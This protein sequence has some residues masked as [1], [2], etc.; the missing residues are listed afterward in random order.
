MTATLWGLYAGYLLWLLAGCVDFHCHR[1]TDLAQ[2]SGLRESVLHLLQTGLM[3][4]MLVAW[5]LLEPSLALAMLMG[6]LVLAHAM[7]GYADTRVAWP[8]RAITPLEQHVHSVL[9]TAPWIVLGVVLYRDGGLAM[10]Q[11]W[12][13]AWRSPLPPASA[14]AAVLAPALLLCVLPLLQELRAAWRARGEPGAHP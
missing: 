7:A 5:M 11:G 14:W 12:D 10:Q 3:G 6:V 4:V 8:R 1:R 2:T 13:W 9:D